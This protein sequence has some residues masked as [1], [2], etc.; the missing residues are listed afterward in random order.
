MA[1]GQ[2]PG[3]FWEHH[4]HWLMYKRMFMFIP[5]KIGFIGIDP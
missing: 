3:I 5:L 2:N 1:M 4:N